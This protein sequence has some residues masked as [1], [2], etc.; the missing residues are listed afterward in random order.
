MAHR[1]TAP[2]AS[3]LRGRVAGH[4][5]SILPT[6]RHEIWPAS[7]PCSAPWTTTLTDLVVGTV[8][9]SGQLCEMPTSDTVV[10]IVHGL[11]GDACSRYC[12]EAA[13]AARQLGVSSLRLELRGA[14][15]AGEDYHHA[16][17]TADLAAALRSEALASYR[18]VALLGYSLGGHLCLGAAIEQLD[19]RVRAVAAVGPPLDLAAVQ[20]AIDGPLMWPYRRYLL[21]ALNDIYRAVARRRPVPTPPAEVARARTI[22]DFDTLTI[23]PRFGF[24]DADDYYQRAGVAR[25]LGELAIPALL[26]AST[27]DPMIPHATLHAPLEQAPPCLETRFIDAGGHMYFPSSVPGLAQDVL[28]WLL[29]RC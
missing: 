28:P 18:H 24:A 26:V 1:L 17:L 6:L 11:G 13:V 8:R 9:L 23:V 16:G 5:W 29:E 12:I 15:L 19:P 22:R 2:V 21:S 14:D 7:A 25:R 3:T 27:R 10:V 4:L 20:R